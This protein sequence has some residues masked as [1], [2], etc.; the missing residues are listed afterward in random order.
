[1][2][3]VD[4]FNSLEKYLKDFHN[5]P[6]KSADEGLIYVGLNEK[7]NEFKDKD[8]KIYFVNYLCMI[9][10]LD[11]KFYE[12]NKE[13]YFKFKSIYKI[14]KFEY[15]LSNIYYFPNAIF[16]KFNVLNK[17]DI[18]KDCFDDFYN[19]YLNSL[20]QN[21]L[22]IS[23]DNLLESMIIDKDINSGVWGTEFCRLILHKLGNDR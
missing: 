12:L 7:Y 1:M 15:G 18:F 3:S 20:I 21:E 2:N 11:L 19:F 14:P 4:F 16:Y 8:K 17:M 10:S 13:N 22:E 5:N 9:V 6:Y 23:L